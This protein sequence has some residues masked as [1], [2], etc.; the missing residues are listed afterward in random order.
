LSNWNCTL[1]TATLSLALAET[2]TVLE[3]VEPFAGALMLTVGGVVSF[4]A[5]LTVTVTLELVVELFEVSVAI[6]RSVCVPFVD[7]VV[8]H[9]YV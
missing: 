9:E 5:L 7:F 4:A 6:A 8:S 2:V 1:A 3:T